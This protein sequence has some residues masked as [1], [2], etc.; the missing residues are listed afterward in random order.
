MV[1]RKT[2]VLQHRMY[3]VLCMSGANSKS[4]TLTR[5]QAEEAKKLVDENIT[6]LLQR[7]ENLEALVERIRQKHAPADVEFTC[8]TR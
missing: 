7:G 2:A 5:E 8:A 1:A 6:K 4:T 3:Y